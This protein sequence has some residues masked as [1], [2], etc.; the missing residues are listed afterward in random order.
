MSLPNS[1]E[2][3]VWIPSRIRR[4]SKLNNYDILRVYINRIYSFILFSCGVKT[5]LTS[6]PN[7]DTKFPATD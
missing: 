3:T 1:N 7:A 2:I 6:G 4:L 5:I